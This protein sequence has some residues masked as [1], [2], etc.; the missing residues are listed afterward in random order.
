VV[1]S[2]ERATVYVI[3]DDDAVRDSLLFLL[4][5]EGFRG[6]GFAAVDAFLAVTPTPASGC[7]VSDL[8]MPV[9]DG[10]DLLRLLPE[11]GIRLPVIVITGQGDAPAAAR[12]LA[13][14]AFDFIEKPAQ[15]TAI[16]GAI[17]AAL[18]T[19]EPDP[20]RAARAR[21]TGRHIAQ[22]AEHERAMLDRMVRG[23]TN[24]GLAAMQGIA[25]AEIELMRARI[26]QR[27]GAASLPDLLRLVIEARR[28]A[29]D[30]GCSA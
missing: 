12:A 7:I 15:D 4:D 29:A 20:A 6:Q 26:M 8:R 9:L 27:M 11:R 3:D 30:Q 21:A 1:T 28:Y 24:Q 25:V 5:V 17:R 14:G 13:A 23:E 16:L 2:G 10:S 18:A 19:G 22:F